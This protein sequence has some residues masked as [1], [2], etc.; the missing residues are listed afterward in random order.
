MLWRG[1]S[2]HP[3]PVAAPFESGQMP[4]GQTHSGYREASP[5]HD[6]NQPFGTVQPELA[7][8]QPQIHQKNTWLQQDSPQSQVGRCPA[9]GLF[10]LLPRPFRAQDRCNGHNPGQRANTGNGT[11]HHKSRLE[12]RRASWWVLTIDE[13]SKLIAEFQTELKLQSLRLPKCKHEGA[14][15]ESSL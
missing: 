4:L 9:S 3:G 11:G 6:D 15:A 8:I 12:S 5:F 14:H 7:I 2:Q 10:Q 13:A 1:E